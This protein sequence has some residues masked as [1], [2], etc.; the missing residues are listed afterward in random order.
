MQHW[1]PFVQCSH[2]CNAVSLFLSITYLACSVTS[3]MQHSQ[4]KTQMCA[5]LVFGMVNAFIAWPDSLSPNGVQAGCGVM[6]EVCSGT[7][8]TK[9]MV[10]CWLLQ[11][12]K[13]RVG[14]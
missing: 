9:L 11:G 5:L 4:H 14:T 12:E 10:A 7:K 6:P 8:A 1:L 3:N 2:S 13:K